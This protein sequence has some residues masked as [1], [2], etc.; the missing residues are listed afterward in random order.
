MLRDSIK[1]LMGETFDLAPR[2]IPDDATIEELEGWDSLNHMQLMLA[3][4]AKFGIRISTS[5][6]LDLVSLDAIQDFLKSQGVDAG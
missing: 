4:E 2:E 6:M 1:Q 5:M 3:V